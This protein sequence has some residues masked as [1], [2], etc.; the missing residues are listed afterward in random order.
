[1]ITDA[2]LLA[3]NATVIAG[4]LIF[5]TI[6]P[7]S[8][9]VSAVIT[10]KTSVLTSTYFT[11]GLLIASLLVLVLPSAIIVPLDTKTQKDLLVA[12]SIL[13][14]AG[15]IGIPYTINVIMKGLKTGH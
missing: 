11:V 1:M 2:D 6:S 13:F 12:A 10:E 14:M 9:R 15:L 4:L 8:T 5:L 7:I 3:A